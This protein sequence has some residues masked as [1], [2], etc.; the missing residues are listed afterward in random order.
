[1][2]KFWRN[3]LVYKEWK[4]VR[5]ITL[6]MTLNLLLF[7]VLQITSRL[8]YIKE[9]RLDNMYD[10][11]VFNEQTKY[12]F[13]SILLR[14]WDD[15][16]LYFIGMC[17][18]IILLVI[19]LFKSE[20][21]NATYGFLASMPF[22]REEMI[23]VKW[24]IGVLSIAISFF[25]TFIFLSIFYITNIEWIQT[26]YNPY[27]IIPEWTII[28]MMLCIAI[29][30]F[31]LF[32]QTL[33][34]KNIVGGVVG[35]LVLVAPMGAV[36][37]VGQIISNQFNL[38]YGNPLI[39]GFEKLSSKLD[40]FR[41]IKTNDALIDITNSTGFH[42]SYDYYGSYQPYMYNSYFLKIVIT[43][44]FTVIFYLLA[45]YAYKRNALENNGNLILFS[46]LEPVFKWGVSI[47]LG[48][49]LS[50]V[51]GMGYTDSIMVMDIFLVLGIIV[52][53]FVSNKAIKICNNS[54]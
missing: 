15:G 1:M 5:W 45:M 46:K 19:F 14:Q 12:W 25:I 32:I 30:S 20:R 43:V 49:L 24:S 54:K 28:N 34:G 38:E 11:Q 22:K 48:L 53:Y 36:M 51:F 33:I 17:I 27:I 23:D 35:S 37:I 10:Q 8:S 18:C 47:C 40:I 3:P 21:E 42:F 41:I 16:I 31:L 7:K 6:L 26:P 52:G 9:R 13:N 39:E 4:S 44:V 2:R 29:F 50:A